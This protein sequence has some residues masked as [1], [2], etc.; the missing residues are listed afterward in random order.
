MNP[1]DAPEAALLAIL[2]E[3]GRGPKRGGI[4]ALWLTLR[5]ARDLLLEP[6]LAE[7]A[8]RRRG[9]H[10]SVGFPALRCRRLSGARWQRR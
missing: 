2:P 3:L 6:P 10:S 8:H 5:V 9:R 1:W 4:F 7:R